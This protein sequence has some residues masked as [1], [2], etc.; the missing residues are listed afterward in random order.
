M[1]RLRNGSQKALVF[2]YTCSTWLFF[3]QKEGFFAGSASSRTTAK[4]SASTQIRP[5]YRNLSFLL[6]STTSTYTGP[7]ANLSYPTILNS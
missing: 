6:G 4:S 5:R 3:V 2:E 7:L 1:L